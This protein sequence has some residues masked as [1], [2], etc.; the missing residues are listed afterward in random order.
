MPSVS[1]WVVGLAI[2]LTMTASG[3]MRL[4]RPPGETIVD[5]ELTI[6]PAPSVTPPETVQPEPRPGF[7]QE[8]PK[9]D[10]PP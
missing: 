4:Q 2:A 1:R 3:C 9:S 5:Q 7:E 10:S 6:N 8:P